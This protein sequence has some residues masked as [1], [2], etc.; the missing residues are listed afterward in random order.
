MQ[1]AKKKASS[2]MDSEG[3]DFALEKPKKKPAAK[4][5]KKASSKIIFGIVTDT[6]QHRFPSFGTSPNI[7][8]SGTHLNVYGNK[9]NKWM[10]DAV[11]WICIV[12]MPIRIQIRRSM[13]MPV[14]ISN[15]GTRIPEQE[16]RKPVF[17]ILIRN[18]LDPGEYVSGSW[19]L[20]KFNKKPNF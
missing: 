9:S 10:N 18:N 8:G 12:L 6:Y 13:S 16:F 15:S 2:D 14:R 3:S 17:R 4:K 5:P 20:T 1:P 11:L 19:K 7:Y